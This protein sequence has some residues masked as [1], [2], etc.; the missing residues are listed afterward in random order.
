MGLAEVRFY[1]GR[2]FRVKMTGFTMAGS[3][4]GASGWG[5]KNGDLVT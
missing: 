2:G 4:G 3:S 1:V 5:M